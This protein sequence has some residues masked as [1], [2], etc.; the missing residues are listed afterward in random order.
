MSTTDPRIKV[1]KSKHIAGA[2]NVSNILR[3]EEYIDQTFSLFFRWL[4]TYAKDAR[5][6]DLNGYI[7][8]A[9]F[10]IIGEVIF[11]KSFGFLRQ[12]EDIGNAIKNSLALNGYVA[13][14]GY[15]RWINIAS[16]A[17]P[18]MTWLSI[19]PMGH[20]FN[21]TRSVLQEREQ[22]MNARFDAVQYWFK[23]NEKFPEKLSI[24][25]IG[26]QALA[27]VGAGSD[28]VAAGIK[29][30]IYHMIRHPDAWNRAHEE[31]KAAMQGG[32][33]KDPVVSFA[34]S[35]QLRYINRPVGLA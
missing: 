10:D 30:F 22:N 3:S 28:T 5:P 7:S 13:V 23:Q 11:S 18:L 26:T 34:G 24:R 31:I 2:Y 20:L 9:T 21:T 4:D 8:F 35:Q 15:F 19:M 27:A 14:A 6:M 16:L 29:G 32:L 1:K 25:D 33:C 12:G 17:N